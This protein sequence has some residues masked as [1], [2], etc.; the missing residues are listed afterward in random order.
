MGKTTSSMFHLNNREATSDQ[1][2]PTYVGVE[3]DRTLSI[4]QHL[5]GAKA[6]TSARAALISCPA[7]TTWGATRKTRRMSTVA[8]VFSAAEYCAV[9]SCCPNIAAVVILSRARCGLSKC[10]TYYLVAMAVADLLVIVSAVILNRITGIYFINSLFSTTPACSFSTVMIYTSRDSSVWL[11][12]AFTFDRF[13]AICC[14]QLKD[15]YCTKKTATVVIAAVCVLSGVKNAP[16]YFTYQPLYTVDGVPWF[17]DIK[18]SFFTEP[19]WKSYDWLDRILTP[20]VPF[21]LIFL[22]NVLTIRHIYVSNRIRNALRGNKEGEDGKDA[23]M[24]SRRK[25]IILL[26]S[27]STSFLLLWVTYVINFMLVRIKG[28]SYISGFSFRNPRYILQESA[29]MLSTLS[30]CTNSFIYAVTQAKFRL[31]LKKAVK[32]PLVVVHNCLRR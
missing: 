17:C 26:F 11:T 31:E 13:A 5:E 15:S 29:N 24:E 16:F 12:V 4:K 21:L 20:S 6:N 18:L 3:L 19:V 30:F 28:G 7:R 9:T 27:I 23:E 2:V 10:V 32:Y 8:L 22:F 25:S 14:R 1:P